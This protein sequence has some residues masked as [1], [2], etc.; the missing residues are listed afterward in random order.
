M[1]TIT[2]PQLPTIPNS[3]IS[4][5]SILPIVDTTG[6]PQTDKVTVGNLANFILNQAGNL[7][8]NGF[9]STYAQSVTNAA[10]PNITSVGTLTSLAVNGNIRLG[11]IT[12]SNSNISSNIS[13]S[14]VNIVS[15][16]TGN[17]NINS[18]NN[19]WTFD[20]TGDLTTPGNVNVVANINGANVIANSFFGN[21]F[22][23]LVGGNLTFSY[24]NISIDVNGS[25]II[26]GSNAIQVRVNNSPYMKIFAPNVEISNFGT[27]PGPSLAI[28]GY[29]DPNNQPLSA[30]LSVQ[31]QLNATQ[32]WDFGIIGQGDNNFTVRNRTNSNVWAFGT[33]GN[34]TLPSD[35]SSI[36]YYNGNPYGMPVGNNGAVQVNWLGSFSNQGGTPDDTYSTLQFD[37]NGMPT[38][39]G[40]NAYQQRVDYSP[41]LQVLAP[42]VESTDFDII[43]GPG[44]TVVGYDDN[45]N[46]P[47][48]AY[49]SV[50][51]QA[52]ATQQWDFG[53]LGNGDNNFTVRNRTNSNVWAFG[54]NGTT[55]FPT[56]DVDIHNGGVQSGEVLQF[57]NPNLQSIITGPT[58]TVNVNAQRIIIQGQRGNGTGEGGDVY[59]WAGDS[60]TAGGDIKIYAGD[61]D[62]ASTGSGGYINLAGGDGFDNGGDISLN[63]GVSANG[64]GGSVS[65]A[66]G[67]SQGNGPPGFIEI[68]GGQGDSTTG[69]Y[70]E[71]TG[72]VGGND[73]GGTVDIIG[74]YGQG[75]P[76]GNVNIAGG[77]SV[78]GFSTYGNVKISAGS[79]SW[80]FNND[81]NLTLPANTF[82]IN[83]AN[84][85]QVQLGGGGLSGIVIQD[86]GTNVVASANTINF[87]G[88]GVTASN[89]SGVATVTISGN[90][91]QISNG[92]SNVSIPDANDNVYITTNDGNSKQ[93]IFNKNGSLRI[94][95]NIDIVGAIIFPQEV[96]S[97]NW[98]TYNIELSQYGRINTNVDFF[99]N[100]NTIGASSIVVSSNAN[101]S[102]NLI[103]S[104]TT[105]IVS[106]P[107]SN[108]NITLDPDGTGV[109]NVLG[110]VVADN[111]SGNISITGNINGTS[112]NVTLVAGSYNY[113]FDNTGNFTLPANS[114]IIMSGESSNVLVGGTV[115]AALH[116]SYTSSWTLVTGTNTVSLSVPLN[117]TYS[118]WVRGNIPSGIVSYTATVVVTNN[119][120]PV[121]GSS[122]GWY[123]EDGNALVLTAIPTQIIGTLNNISN[124][125]VSTT[126]ANVFTFGITNNSGANAVVNYGYTR[127]G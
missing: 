22:G 51:D 5:S 6:T 52:N 82:A 111:F 42:E 35:S 62:N 114:Y 118:I 104:N 40:T 85:N 55:T 120:V 39:D 70:V 60:D 76:G 67:T 91:N 16:G 11:D 71:I 69:G 49:L 44:I 72:G 125:V 19:I 7:L 101:V 17:I 10:Q 65:I 2:I 37:S 78:G 93:W 27:T 87:I 80:N 34:L 92:N 43:A 38:L 99:A 115:N 14:D 61:A 63:G 30:Y 88:N 13:N 32:Q 36:N 8:V 59:V 53:I 20:S 108:G 75:G 54:T 46:I 57:G 103:L 117:G 123:Y 107:G 98:S 3:N 105:Q 116:T 81:G 47:R 56:A 26:D 90:S 74:G 64:A 29:T 4:V 95:G 58:P 1:T 126:T 50:Q 97:I 112:P 86:E 79:S 94:P 15:N 84:G 127:L 23:N 25:P 24:S 77:G 122:Y 12:F 109:V 33:D 66:G 31:D 113:V 102:G 21:L 18:N 106:T 45:Y 89:V 121:L 100:A 96:S 119:N 9:L 48:S 41:Y 83:Y 68:T 110:N 28:I 124:A 73:R